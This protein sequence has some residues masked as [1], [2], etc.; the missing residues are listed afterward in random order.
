MHYVYDFITDYQIGNQN[1]ISQNEFKDIQRNSSLA[2]F[3]SCIMCC[4]LAMIQK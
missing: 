2:V 1:I 4:V 3:M